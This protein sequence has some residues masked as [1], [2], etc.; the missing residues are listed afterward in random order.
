MEAEYFPPKEVV[1]LQN[2]I[3]T[4]LCIPVTGAVDIIVQKDEQDQIIG[5]VVSGEMF[6]E[7]GVLYNT[8]QSFTFQTSEISQ[9]LWLDGSALLRTIHT[10]K[11]GFFIRNNFYKVLFFLCINY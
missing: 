1:I 10:D 8:P 3:P 9:M 2:E 5:K 4:N 11:M 6:G 7:S